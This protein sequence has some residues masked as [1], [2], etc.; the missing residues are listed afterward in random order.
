MKLIC[1][2]GDLADAVGKVYKA[3][4]THSTTPILEGIRLQAHDGTLKLSAT[5]LELAIEKVIVADVKVEGETVAPGRLF[6]ELM[7]KLVGEQI[8][9]TL[10]ETGS[11]KIAFGESHVDLMCL[12]ADDFP[13]LTSADDAEKFT[14]KKNDFKD[15]VGKVAFCVS[16]NDARPMLKGV[17]FEVDPTAVTAVAL[18]GYRLARCQ[19]TVL[20]AVGEMRALLS[21]RCL[22]EIA[23]LVEDTDD[24]LEVCVQ[25]NYLSVDLGTTRVTSRLLDMDYVN[26]KKMIPGY[27]ETMATLPREQ[28]EAALERAVLVSHNDKSSLVRFELRE[29]MLQ[30]TSASDVGNLTEKIL[31]KLDGK[32]LSITF[33]ARYF[34]EVLRYMDCDSVCVKFADNITPCVIVPSGALEELMYLILPIR[35]QY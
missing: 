18:D 28:L 32:D 9:L 35:I 16:A 25:K 22:V 26:Y 1:N 7:R 14:V 4:S 13:E 30:L 21:A 12:S 20:S 2:G 31:I 17:L 3:V 24:P 27:F 11:L 6:S 5:D 8:E 23:R 10:S 15:L 29:G 33:N 19:K 34:I